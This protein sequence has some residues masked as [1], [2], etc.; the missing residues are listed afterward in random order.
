MQNNTILLI[1]EEI[2]GNPKNASF[3]W[4]KGNHFIAGTS[5][6]TIIEAKANDTGNYTCRGSN[7]FGEDSARVE[8][9]VS[10]EYW[11]LDVFDLF[12][13]LHCFFLTIKDTETVFFG[14]IPK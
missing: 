10:C 7:G 4:Y 3:Q 11:T 8:V 14:G 2:D 12:Y 5:K 13:Y 1:C 9:Y 6:F